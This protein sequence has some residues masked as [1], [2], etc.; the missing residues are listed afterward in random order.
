VARHSLGAALVEQ[1]KIQEAALH[2]ARA[3]E[4]SPGYAE[5]QS[6]LG[7]ALV[8]QGKLDEGIEHYRAAIASRP[9]LEKTHFNL[10]NAL[11]MKG[12]NDEAAKEYE[13]TIQLNPGSLEAH[14]ALAAILAGKGRYDEAIAHLRASL[15]INPSDPNLHFDLANVLKQ[16]GNP[17][18]AIAEYKKSL[19]LKPND[20]EA[21]ENIGMLLAQNG[22]V[23]AAIVHFSQAAALRPN[24]TVHYE[25]ALAFTMQGNRQNAIDQYRNALRLK[26][27]FIL[28]LND[29][30]WIFATA[31]EPALRNGPEAVQLAEKACALAGESEPRFLGTLDA[32]YAE[33]GRFDDAARTAKR[34]RDLALAASQ[35]SIAKKADERLALY[36]KGLPYH[37]STQ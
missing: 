16:Q 5:S 21:L 37:Q 33:A 4:L 6:D 10:A 18:D 34:T 13:T 20:P 29:L 11:L 23:S 9:Y 22:D 3:V 25:L 32:A 17:H 35:D 15:K 36:G 19:E 2:F 27:D 24:P 30:A 31:P 8:F 12:Q 26:P 28:A 1:G 14:N 7:L